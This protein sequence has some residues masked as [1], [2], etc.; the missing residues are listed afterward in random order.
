[1][2][3]KE[4]ICIDYAGRKQNKI[5]PQ[6]KNPKDLIK[7]LLETNNLIVEEF[8]A[9]DGYTEFI[10][11][12][13][14]SKKQLVL[15][16]YFSNYKF[17]VERPN[18]ININLGQN[19]RSPFEL[20]SNDNASTKTLIL[21]IY[22]FDERDDIQDAI[23]V[24]CPIKDRNYNGNPSLRARIEVIQEARLYANASW[25][26]NANDS[27]SAFKPL[28]FSEAINLNDLGTDFIHNENVTK[29]VDLSSK[30]SGPIPS[31]TGYTV[32]ER[33]EREAVVYL[34]RW[35][36]HDI[37]KIGTTVNIERR[38]KEFNQYIPYHEI[39]ETD[40]W[41]LYLAKE[42]VSQKKAYEV[43]QNILHDNELSKHNSIGERFKCNFNFIQKAIQ[44]HIK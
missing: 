33:E 13:I 16:I 26:N 28:S 22:V 14:I 4:S 32:N 20:H 37:W 38:I 25:I 30:R 11:Q 18:H 29:K 5:L 3:A 35:G 2:A 24:N 8:N 19:I 41:T 39:P 10:C 27:F 23:F 31:L 42:F 40:I 1:M 12:N 36:K 7:K 15:N 34:A 43:E 9:M 21:G 44:S 6:A 17:D